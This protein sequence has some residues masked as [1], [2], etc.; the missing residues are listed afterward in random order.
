[1]NK[2]AKL[3]E[4]ASFAAKKHRFQKRKG[5]DGEPYV[6]HPLEVA[7][8]IATVGKVEDIDILIAAILHDTVEDTET[9]RDELAGKFGETVA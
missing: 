3:V 1:M 6:N 8:L 2:I 9:T 7:N 5:D 4:A